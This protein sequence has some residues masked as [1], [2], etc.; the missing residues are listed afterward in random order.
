M[1]GDLKTRYD[2]MGMVLIGAYA[3]VQMSDK[4]KSK[5]AHIALRDGGDIY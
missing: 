3:L 4:E 5:D 2:L 1:R